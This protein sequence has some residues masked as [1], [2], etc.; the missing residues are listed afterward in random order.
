MERLSRLPPRRL[1][2]IAPAFSSR[3]TEGAEPPIV[4]PVIPL[5]HA[6]DD[7]GPDENEEEAEPRAEPQSGTWR[8]MF[9]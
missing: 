1:R 7:P 5:I 9:E 6:P 3:P 4:A 8:K 2:G